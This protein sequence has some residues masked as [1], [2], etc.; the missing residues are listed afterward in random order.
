MYS[1][2]G[3]TLLQRQLR[4]PEPRTGT[5]PGQIVAPRTRGRTSWLLARPTE[6]FKPPITMLWPFL[7]ISAPHSPDTQRSFFRTPYAIPCSLSRREY[8]TY[9]RQPMSQP[10]FGFSIELNG[11]ELGCV[12][13]VNVLLHS[14]GRNKYR[15]HV[16]AYPPLGYKST[17]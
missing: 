17:R 10:Q 12:K 16:Q 13:S 8:S 5:A 4:S 3:L 2:N 9:S 1:L 14:M 7:P 15:H 11:N 6:P